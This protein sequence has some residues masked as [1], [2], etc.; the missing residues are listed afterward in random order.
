MTTSFQPDSVPDSGRSSAAQSMAARLAE[1]R[2][3]CARGA[4]CTEVT[5][6]LANEAASEFLSSYSE[7]GEYLGDAIA[8]LAE[9]STL[10][11]PCLSQPGQRAT[12]PFLVERLSDSFDPAYGDLY[13]R[14]FAQMIDVCRRLPAAAD[15]DAALR[16]FDLATERDLLERKA[17]LRWRPPMV[18][19]ETQAPEAQAKV[20]KVLILSRVTLGADVAITSVALQKARQVFPHAERVLLGSAKLGELFGGDTLL[21][22]RE[23]GYKTAG[24]LLDRLQNWLPLLAAVDSE[25]RGFPADQVVLLDPDSR[26]LQLG[27]LPALPDE[28]NY[29]F[30]ESRRYG[31]G[32]SA[33]LSELTLRWLN[34]QFGAG[35][36]ILPAVHLRKSDRKFARA[37]C[38]RLREQAHR[39]QSQEGQQ[40]QGGSKRLVAMSFGVGGN[41][42]KRLP[43]PFERDVLRG[44]LADGCT[45]LLDKGAG[46]EEV[47]RAARLV[48]DVQGGGLPVLE[49][50]PNGLPSALENEPLRFRL[51]TWHGGIGAF[52]AL[53]AECDEYVGY[54]S[55][56]QHIA[57]A[58][59]V[60]PIS[61]FSR[62]APEVFR[63]RWK[64][65]GPGVSKQVAELAADGTPR[66]LADILGEV[67]NLHRGLH[68]EMPRK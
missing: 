3:L 61:I 32:I 57:A 29:F 47:E 6:Q 38:S 41:A 4:L 48:E 25:I 49:L 67:L 8:L 65:T 34:E 35:S 46:A 15:L 18:H 24:G 63:N 60:P 27:L 11:D 66:A 45:V 43:D 53:T 16:R 36:P 52:S 21:R 51:I 7:R 37:L 68:R 1:F 9:I 28:S 22:I 26:L 17:R 33:S 19:L 59:G 30:F 31:E 62:V 10:E 50:S 5:E 13:D 44:I 42:E 12:F 54:D 58:L 14:A 56:G 64:P 2:A 23:V 39:E 20:R 55:S 40:G